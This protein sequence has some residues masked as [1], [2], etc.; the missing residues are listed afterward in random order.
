VVS[1]KRKWIVALLLVSAF[2]VCADLKLSGVLL[3]QEGTSALINGQA[4][5]VG[6]EVMGFTVVAIN[7]QSATLRQISTGNEMVLA[8]GDSF[9]RSQEAKEISKNG[10][11]VRLVSGIMDS[12]ALGFL[13]SS[14]GESLP[15]AAAM[16]AVTLALN[17]FAIVTW[18]KICSKAG[19]P[20]W[21]LFIPFYNIYVMLKIADKPGWWLLLMFVPVVNVIVSILV[22]I[23]IAQNF[24]KGAGFSLGL[25]FLPV[26]FYPVLAF[27]RSEYQG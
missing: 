26:I 4:Y 11:G 18:W 27:G 8:V 13:Q 23:G 14:D 22:Q 21:S 2:A 5:R 1:F 16:L 10:P 19:Q 7:S 6:E 12:E 9:D 25:I 24:G 17:L 3:S 15:V 20:G